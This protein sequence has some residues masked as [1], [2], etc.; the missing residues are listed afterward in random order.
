MHKEPIIGID[1]GTT[2]SC[3]AIVEDSGNV[4]LI[5]YK[6][7]EYTIPSIFA[8]DDKGNEL[9]GFEAKRQWQLNPRN[10]V[11]G[12]KRLVG[13]NYS[14]DVVGVMKKAVA[15][16]MRAG[17]KNDVT[18]DVGKKEFTLQEISAKILGKIRDVASNY[19]KTPIKRAVVTVPAYFNDRQRQSVKDAGKL[20]DLEV[21]RIINEPTAAALAYGVGK[22]L[23]EKVVIYD[24]GGGTFDVSIIE[25]R[26][27]VFEV[28]ATGGDVFLGGIDF[29]NAIIHHVLKDFAAK[30][31]IDLA[32]DPV[33]MQRIKDLAE[34]TKIDLSA[35]EEVPF[36]IPFITMTAQGQP[37]N[38]EMK[39][40]RKMLEQLT[41]QLV[42]RTLQMVA[43]VLV[44]SGL[45]T[46]DIDE[47]MLVGGQT[48]MPVVQDRLTKF[49]G[50][51]PSKGVHPD[52]AVAIGA[53]LYAHSLEDNTNLRIQLLDVIP[54]A[55]GLERGDGGFHVVFPRNASIPNA[56]QLLATTSIDNQTELAMRIYQGDHDTVARNDLLG[57]FTFSGIMPAKAG[58]VNV[59]IIFDVSVEGIL[60]MRAK[61][62]A[63]GRE[64][65]TTVRVTQS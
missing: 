22:T 58:T 25:I 27:R 4:K 23:K 41:N 13:V 24:L 59:E 39:F 29:D 43:R 9:I 48:R 18:L 1:L 11:Y 53:A 6:G 35:R 50:K 33:A 40:T 63:T 20:I 54:M 30:T 17:A 60:T 21:V 61:D 15:Y 57:E 19:L 14:S 34:R 26:D 44:D 5:P 52:E 7:G 55:I 37:L 12:A 2:N 36:N 62:P 8:I 49:F 64:M 38:I 16:N 47:V 10:T 51:P 45:S 65:K 3:A 42:D 46:K 56:K 31:G 32:T 28:K